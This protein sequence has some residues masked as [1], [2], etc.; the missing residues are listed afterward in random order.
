MREVGRKH[1]EIDADMLTFL[2]RHAHVS[3]AVVGEIRTNMLKCEE[4]RRDARSEHQGPSANRLAIGSVG[5]AF[6]ALDLLNGP[7]PAARAAPA[8]SELV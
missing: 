4:Q 1:D 8:R 5:C 3:H 7:N 6:A 2:H